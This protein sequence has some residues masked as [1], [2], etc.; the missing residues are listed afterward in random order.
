MRKNNPICFVVLSQQYFKAPPHLHN[1]F[2]LLLKLMAVSPKKPSSQEISMRWTVPFMLAF[3][4]LSLGLHAAVLETRIVDVEVEAGDDKV[5]IL[6]ESDG[7]VL[8]ADAQDSKLVEAFKKASE[9][10]RYLRVNFD[11]AKG[12]VEGVVLLAKRLDVA[13]APSRS[14][15][16]DESFQPTVFNSLQDAQNLFNTMDNQT[17]NDSECYNRAH[18]WAY[19]LYTQY[20][21]NSLKIFIFFTK[22]YIRE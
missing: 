9:T 4:F 20:R 22:R 11:D 14:N 12:T 19:D 7:R 21:I 5:M 8:W 18:G 2:V 16:K 15:N 6:A 1:C 3:S 13:E 10:G 17:K